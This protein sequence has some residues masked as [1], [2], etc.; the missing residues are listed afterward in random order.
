MGVRHYVRDIV[1]Q[2]KAPL[3]PALQ[4]RDLCPQSSILF[5]CKG[6]ICRSPFA[7]AYALKKARALN[8]E[9]IMVTS[10]GIKVLS[11]ETPPEEA[12]KAAETCGVLMENYRSQPVTQEMIYSHPIVIAMEWSHVK[13]L[14]RQFDQNGTVV[15]LLAGYDPKKSST[16]FDQFNIRDPYGKSVEDFTNCYERISRC[17]DRLFDQI[18]S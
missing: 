8:F 13:L 16:G 4:K 1:W 18:E 7:E 15:N 2:L 17:V 11:P 12:L 9:D 6:N 14:R 10:G 5:V 3:M